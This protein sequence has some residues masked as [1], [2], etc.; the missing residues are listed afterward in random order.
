MCGNHRPEYVF[1]LHEEKEEKAFPT[2]IHHWDSCLISS[3]N[4]DSLDHKIFIMIFFINK[5]H[6]FVKHRDAV[7]RHDS[8][9]S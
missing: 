8:F 5:N 3:F 1:C 2:V 7:L 4:T 9:L 6:D